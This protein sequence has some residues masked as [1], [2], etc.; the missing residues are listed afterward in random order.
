MHSSL[1]HPDRVLVGLAPGSSFALPRFARTEWQQLQSSPWAR[2]GVMRVNRRREGKNWT[3][4]FH[5]KTEAELLLAANLSPHFP[6]H[7]NLSATNKN[8]DEHFV[9]LLHESFVRLVFS[10][11]QR[12]RRGCSARRLKLEVLHLQK[13]EQ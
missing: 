8:G 2:C 13:M 5:H 1:C 7:I 9:C 11:T 4:F 10:R 3:H 6:A 12:V